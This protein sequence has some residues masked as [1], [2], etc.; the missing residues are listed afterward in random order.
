RLYIQA[1]LFENS[2][3]CAEVKRDK[4]LWEKIYS[5]YG[6][7]KKYINIPFTAHGCH[8]LW[9]RLSGKGKSIIESVTREFSVN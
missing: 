9:L 4:G 5:G 3:I 7:E 8:E 6:N 2:Y 1:Q